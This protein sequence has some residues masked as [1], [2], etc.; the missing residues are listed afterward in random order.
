M[1]L[2]AHGPTYQNG[3]AGAFTR[4][5]DTA[6]DVRSL[7]ALLGEDGVCTAIVE[8]EHGVMDVRVAGG[9]GYLL[10]TGP[11]ITGGYSVGLPDSPAVT[12]SETGFPVGSG[13]SLDVF[14]MVLI[15]FWHTGLLPTAIRWSRE[16]HSFGGSV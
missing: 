11:E 8:G 5:L 6:E 7:V 15:E 3:V 16:P 9:L 13:V 10:Y 14:T 12:A 1:T 2:T 4:S